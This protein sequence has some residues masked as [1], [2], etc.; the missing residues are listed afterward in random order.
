MVNRERGRAEER[1]EERERAEAEG[2]GRG[3]GFNGDAIAAVGGSGSAS[4]N[5]SW[6]ALGDALCMQNKRSTHPT[7]WVLS[8]C[9]TA[10]LP[11]PSAHQRFSQLQSTSAAVS[12]VYRHMVTSR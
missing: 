7:R 8:G 2:V 6:Y 3:T 1:A 11:R 12:P 5:G 4:S 9:P 10:R